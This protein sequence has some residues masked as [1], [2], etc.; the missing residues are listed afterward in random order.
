MAENKG[1]PP[2]TPA[3]RKVN[4]MIAIAAMLVTIVFAVVS[5]QILPETVA[6]QPAAFHTG[7]PD[8]PKWVAVVLPFGISAYS[9][10]SC[11]SY[12]KQALICLVGYA[13]NIAFWMSN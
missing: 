5:W 8:I 1:L 3:E 12:R 11:V 9:A 4:I 6:T 2:V 13:L 7:A 10:I